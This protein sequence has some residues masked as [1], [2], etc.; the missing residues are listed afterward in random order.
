M[1]AGS[2][3]SVARDGTFLVLWTTE[4]LTMLSD[5]QMNAGPANKEEKVA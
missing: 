4:V 5:T 1:C 2:L 3:C